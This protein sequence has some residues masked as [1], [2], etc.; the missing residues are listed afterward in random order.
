MGYKQML[1][2][3]FGIKKRV[4]QP[5]RYPR[6]TN[7]KY[8]MLLHTREHIRS[9]YLNIIRAY[10]VVKINLTWA[11]SAP[12]CTLFN[13]CVLTS[14]MVIYVG[15]YYYVCVFHLSYISGS[16]VIVLP[17]ENQLQP[18]SIITHYT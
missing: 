9:T 4:V 12:A 10:K 6:C 16:F 13:R 8:A 15:I 17:H 3:Y 2:N 7:S 14:C 18:G 11:G 1:Y 5:I